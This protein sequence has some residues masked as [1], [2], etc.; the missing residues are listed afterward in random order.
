MEAKDEEQAQP[1]LD[2]KSRSWLGEY[3]APPVGGYPGNGAFGSNWQIALRCAFNATLLGCIIW[4]PASEHYVNQGFAKYV[5]L[6]ILMIFF[7]IHKVFGVVVDNTSGV[8]FGTIFA[9]LNIFILRGF[10]P[11][12]VTPEHSVFS[13]T[14][15][16]GWLDLALYDM[17]FLVADVRA[18]TRCFALAHHTGF[19][20]SFLNPNDATPF[21]KN[22][23][24]NVNGTAFQCVYVTMIA[25]CL[26]ML[27]HLL[28]YPFQ[29]AKASMKDNAKEASAYVA[30]TFVGATAYFNQKK[31][32][33]EIERQIR[34]ADIAEKTVA[35]LGSSIGG[36]WWEGFDLGSG[37]TVRKVHA[38]HATLMGEL[39]D[40]VKA[41][42]AAI[43]SE[44]FEDSHKKIMAAIGE[45]SISLV[46]NTGDLLMFA[47]YCARDGDIDNE[48][49][50]K[51]AGK[52]DA[53]EK[54][55]KAV[56]Q[57]FDKERRE[58]G[59]P[60]HEELLSE[61][62][63]V[64]AI[65][66]YARLVS[67]F[68]KDLTENP[69][70]GESPAS[71]FATGL[72]HTFTLHEIPEYHFRV[73][74][75]T[76]LA[77]MVAF[78]YGVYFDNYGGACAITAVFLAS[79]RTSPDVTTILNI[80]LAVTIASCV[81][82]IIFQRSCQLEMFLG[83]WVLP[84]A[85][86]FFWWFCLY[87]YFA[88]GTFELIGLLC[89]ALSAFVLVTRCPEVMNGSAQAI[90]MWVRIRGFILALL[91]MTIAEVA[92]TKGAL[93][94][95]AKDGIADAIEG[96]ER[97]LNLVFAGE[98]PANEKAKDKTGKVLKHSILDQISKGIADASEF[99]GAAREE[100]RFARAPWNYPLLSDLV[101]QVKLLDLDF[102]LLRAG[103]EGGN[104]DCKD[105]FDKI[106]QVPEF[107]T[108]KGDLLQT[109]KSAADLSGSLLGHTNGPFGGIEIANDQLHGGIEG[110]GE[111]E[112]YDDALK[113]VNNVTGVGFPKADELEPNIENDLCVQI[114]IVFLML[115]SGA[116]HVAGIIKSAVRNS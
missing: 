2:K 99:G 14:S 108:M 92:S 107:A 114:S 31:P 76:W 112:G 64:F 21:S 15:I 10:F 41:I 7:N 81:G 47:T 16:V 34:A 84:V 73:A 24:L 30:K 32:S 37:G 8:L 65:S 94:T 38:N 102:K 59:A 39:L 96:L 79:T 49:K 115:K 89:A 23:K 83:P 93:T 100:P 27:A 91:I 6:T 5:P 1:F 60:I 4:I 53:V 97:S 111:L 9:F 52:I 105:L 62:F 44:G 46:D 113:G 45:Q 58:F 77:L 69:P 82:A 63:F 42:Q 88:G 104:G 98:D 80:L 70:K 20:L 36:A 95:V 109:L 68:A 87:V 28:P 43:A 35:G 72:A 90:V 33:V 48:E 61:S 75:R 18:M 86:F 101:S 22:F 67:K 66:K 85:C 19:M 50:A 116:D 54:D 71:I 11:D 110:V 40:V 12:G 56:G 17:F 3:D 55:M 26:T 13:A 74:I 51:L 29:F 103:T 25:C 78:L 106:N 57:A